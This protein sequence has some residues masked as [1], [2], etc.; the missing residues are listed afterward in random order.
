MTQE[1]Q[2]LPELILID[3]NGLVESS[4]LFIIA[5]DS[6]KEVKRR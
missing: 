4:I 2:Q 3:F 5:N 6:R 1:F